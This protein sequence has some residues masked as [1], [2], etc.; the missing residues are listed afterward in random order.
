MNIVLNWLEDRHHR[1]IVL[2]CVFT[3]SAWWILKNQIGFALPMSQID[4]VT[5]LTLLS[6]LKEA[7][8][9]T[10]WAGIYLDHGLDFIR[11]IQ[12]IHLEDWVFLILGL[13]FCFPIK[14]YRVHLL[15]R[16]VVGVELGLN[17]GLGLIVLNALNSTDTLMILTTV[18]GFAQIELILSAILMTALFAYVLRLSFHEYSD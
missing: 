1:L 16:L 3:L 7:T 12:A 2:F 15:A 18:R 9:L 8:V 14:N 4:S 13:L 17:L 10:R 11:L 5:D 6:T